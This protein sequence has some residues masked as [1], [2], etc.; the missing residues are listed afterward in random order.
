MALSPCPECRASI[1]DQAVAC[2]HCGFPVSDSARRPNQVEA[3]S[4]KLRPPELLEP[5]PEQVKNDPVI[6]TMTPTAKPI[7]V[8]SEKATTERQND[9]ALAALVLSC[10]SCICVPSSATSGYL[11]LPGGLTLG[12]TAVA[13]YRAT[14]QAGRWNRGAMTVAAVVI[15]VIFIVGSAERALRNLSFDLPDVSQTKGQQPTLRPRRPVPPTGEVVGRQGRYSL[16]VPTN[17]QIMG[18]AETVKAG[19]DLWLAD[20]EHSLSVGVKVFSLPTSLTLLDLERFALDAAKKQAP[21]YAFVGAQDVST[22]IGVGR[23]L[24]YRTT[25]KTEQV[26]N[27]HLIVLGSDVGFELLATATSTDF[28]DSEHELRGVVTSI[29]PGP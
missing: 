14:F 5:R 29:R 12:L 2:P 27:I 16:Q 10:L 20:T 26:E 23:V 1:S 7:A 19:Y 22:R 3:P 6:S 17:W 21:P 25:S 13:V 18:E 15:N 28:A 24:R 9:V 4:T 8:G 11:A